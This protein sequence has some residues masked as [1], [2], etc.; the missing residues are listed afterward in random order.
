MLGKLNQTKGLTMTSFRIRGLAAGPFQHLFGLSDSALSAQGVVRM[1][2]DQYPGFPDRIEMR[3]LALGESALLVNYQHQPA[4]NP[5]QS[6]HAIFVREGAQVPYDRI[7]EIP[8]VLARRMI[9]LRAFD[10]DH[11]MVEADLVDGQDLAP[12]IRS[13]F[14]NAQIAYLHAHN[15]K[16]GCFAARIDR[17][18]D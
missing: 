14:Q 6:S 15:A 18:A 10:C 8:E 7:D 11:M 17:A 4:A 9:S 13:Y 2:V 1:I 3:D 16:R 5:Y 12:A